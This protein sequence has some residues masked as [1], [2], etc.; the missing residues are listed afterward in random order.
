MKIVKKALVVSSIV[1]LGFIATGCSKKS[2]I[3]NDRYIVS[4]Q[5]K[6][7]FNKLENILEVKIKDYEALSNRYV[8]YTSSTDETVIY[9]VILNEDIFKTTEKVS[10]VNIKA[11][12]NLFVI[13]YDDGKDSVE[14][15]A[16][17]KEVVL[18]KGSYFDVTVESLSRTTNKKNDNY[19]EVVLKLTTKQLNEASE[20]SFYK[21]T[22]K[23]AKNSKKENIEDIVNNY[24]LAKITEE[25]AAEYKKGDS[26]PTGKKSSYIFASEDDNIDFY[27]ENTLKLVLSMKASGTKKVLMLNDN[28]LVQVAKNVGSNGKYDAYINGSYYQIETYRVDL[29]K[30]TYSRINDF[31]Y[32]IVGSTDTY[33]YDY[34][35]KKESVYDGIILKQVYKITDGVSLDV[36]DVCLDKNLKVVQDDQ[37]YLY[38][39]SSYYDL[40]NGNYATNSGSVLYITDK[41]G[42][43]K[44][45]IN[46]SSKVFLD[47]KVIVQTANGNELRF[48]DFNGN[49][50][51]N[52][53]I[54]YSSLYYMDYNSLFY[55]SLK[56]NTNHVIKYDNGSIISDEVVDYNVKAYTTHNVI[57]TSSTTHYYN[58]Y[59]YFYTTEL[60]DNNGDNVYDAFDVTYY[61]LAGFELGSISNSY[62]LSYASTTD[63]FGNS[64]YVYYSTTSFTDGVATLN[65]SLLKQE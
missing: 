37:M 26:Y 29:K 17:N 10:D 56:D 48:V 39:G 57:S 18:P 11:Y 8:Y 23:S 3:L 28:A 38:S 30:R 12:G 65:I 40:G 47:A 54:R 35:S 46:G 9:D 7:N 2:V 6:A 44:K 50:I 61:D 25:E 13:Y 32:Y 20:V 45:T 52:E 14:V 15:I 4:K 62:R 51:N 42:F 43:V 24:T 31:K 21:I 53:V 58:N 27:D 16:S 41:N 60:K 22:R 64:C 55:V 19:S 5:T 49:Y 36:I 59:N 1:A 33:I 34:N 63:Q